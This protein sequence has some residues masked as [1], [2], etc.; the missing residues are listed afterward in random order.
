MPEAQLAGAAP[1]D[2][3]LGAGRDA[4]RRSP[5]RSPRRRRPSPG[6]SRRS[7]EE[8]T[9]GAST[10]APASHWPWP[11]GNAAPPAPRDRSR[12]VQDLVLNSPAGTAAPAPVPRRRRT[13]PP[14]RHPCPRGLPALRRS[15]RAPRPSALASPVRTASHQGSGQ[16]P[17]VLASTRPELGHG[18]Q[19]G[20]PSR[21][22]P[23]SP[24][25]GALSSVRH[26][27][28]ALRSTKNP[29]STPP[30]RT[31]LLWLDSRSTR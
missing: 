20:W 12:P 14:R 18:D 2:D 25:R 4:G 30:R 8:I 3:D 22:W 11:S 10:S 28:P 16:A 29:L 23:R 15:L 27:T 6:P 31:F 19:L 26:P 24:R 7:R 1:F 9:R 13:R 21:H 17:P 5:S